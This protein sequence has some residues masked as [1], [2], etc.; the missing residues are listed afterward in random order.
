MARLYAEKGALFVADEQNG[1]VYFHGH[2]VSVTSGQVVK[3]FGSGH[4]LG[5]EVCMATDGTLISDNPQFRN[6]LTEPF[7]QSFSRECCSQAEYQVIARHSAPDDS[8]VLL[9]CLDACYG[10][11]LYKLFNVSRLKSCREKVAVIIHPNLQHLVPDYVHEI[12]LV[13]TAVGNQDNYLEG[14]HEFIDQELSSYKHIELLEADMSVDLGEVS[15]DDFTK[16]KPFRFERFAEGAPYQVCLLLRDDRFWLS[17]PMDQWLYLVWRKFDLSVL[18]RFLQLKERRN[19]YRMI[20]AVNQVINVNWLAIG[21]E[22]SIHYAMVDDQR[23][24]YQEFTQKEVEWCIHYSNSHVSIGVHGS[25]MLIPS[26]LSGAF[27]SLVPKFKIPNYSEDFIPRKEPSQRMLFTA[28]NVP[29]SIRPSELARH[30][31]SLVQG[32]RHGLKKRL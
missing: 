16:V 32:Y 17:S 11:A 13:K 10:H 7:R 28:R 22:K 21:I 8:V 27:I 18:K 9:N 15:M 26:Y 4:F 6:W 29:A 14:F 2:H 31:I 5:N 30:I 12:W 20:K 24:T 23:M 3:S 1:R 19:Y 25:N